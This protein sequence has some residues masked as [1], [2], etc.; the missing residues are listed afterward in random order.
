M[1]N[2]K[3]KTIMSRTNGAITKKLW[4]EIP[5]TQ[6]NNFIETNNYKQVTD[7]EIYFVG[8]Y[9]NETSFMQVIEKD[10]STYYYKVL[11]FDNIHSYN[12]VGYKVYTCS[13]Y[14][15]MTIHRM[16]ALAFVPGYKKG[17]IVDHINGVKTDLR[18]EN[19]RW[20]TQSENV[21]AAW[22]N[23]LIKP[24]TERIVQYSWI[25]QYLIL[26]HDRQNIIPMTPDE[27]IDWRKEHNLPITSNI[28]GRYKK[29]LV[30]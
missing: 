18:I 29:Y 16:L 20:V 10:S 13:P 26:N 22:N 4:N 27:Y 11:K 6:F 8:W 14:R 28:R 1:A 19:L 5:K 24:I 2:L 17:L 12:N 23:G 21:K 3:E 25:G 7:G 15:T 9:I 30:Q